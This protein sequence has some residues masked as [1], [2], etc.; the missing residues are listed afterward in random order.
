[1][2]PMTRWT[3][4]TFA[5]R[6]KQPKRVEVVVKREEGPAPEPFHLPPRPAPKPLVKMELGK[7]E[8]MVCEANLSMT[9]AKALSMLSQIRAKVAWIRRTRERSGSIDGLTDWKTLATEEY[10]MLLCEHKAWLLQADGERAKERPPHPGGF[11]DFMRARHA[12][13][14]DRLLSN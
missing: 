11:S 6:D 5:S 7:A 9:P 10:T 1:M 3:F 2:R 14:L 12:E 13:A 8:V 4:Q